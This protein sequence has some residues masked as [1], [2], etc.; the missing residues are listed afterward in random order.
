M[1]DRL[2]TIGLVVAGVAAGFLM[3]GPIGTNIPNA[4]ES[5]MTEEPRITRAYTIQPGPPQRTIVVAYYERYRQEK[6][7]VPVPQVEATYFAE[8][9]LEHLEEFQA[10]LKVYMSIP[11][12]PIRPTT[13]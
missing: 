2:I 13:P 3:R 5:K 10:E 7:S 6:G 12:G 9:L 4:G 8:Y 11:R 1:K